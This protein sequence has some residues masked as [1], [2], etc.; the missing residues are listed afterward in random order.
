MTNSMD[1]ILGG[2]NSMLKSNFVWEAQ[3]ST[4]EIIRQYDGGQNINFKR[5]KENFDKVVFFC[6]IG[7]EKTFIVDLI[8][9][10]I[11]IN[12]RQENL[13]EESKKEK[14]NI[15]LIYTGRVTKDTYIAEKKVVINFYHILGF[16]YNDNEGKN[17]KILLQIDNQGNV[18]IGD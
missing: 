17:H 5:V 7:K 14:Y 3:L 18:I 6:L 12:H 1:M 15:R 13:L 4:G 10:I 16:Q 11:F 8:D 9:G 2:D